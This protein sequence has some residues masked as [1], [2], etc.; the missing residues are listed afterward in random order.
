[1][2]AIWRKHPVW[3]LGAFLYKA[4]IIFLYKALI[5]MLKKITI[6]L[7]PSKHFKYDQWKADESEWIKGL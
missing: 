5:N 6:Y 4:L 3:K 7:A 1:M 2:F